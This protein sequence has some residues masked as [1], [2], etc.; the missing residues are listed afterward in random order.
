M[1]FPRFLPLQK[2]EEILRLEHFG[3][4][5]MQKNYLQSFARSHSGF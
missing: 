2:D 1:Y 5:I 4:I 3:K